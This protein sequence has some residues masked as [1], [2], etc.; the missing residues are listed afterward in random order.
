MGIGACASEAAAHERDRNV[1][2]WQQP[3]DFQHLHGVPAVQGANTGSP[4]HSEHICEVRKRKQQGEDAAR[5]AGI[6][7]VQSFGVGIRHMESEWNGTAAVRHSTLK[8]F[9]LT[10]ITD[11]MCRTTRSDWLAWETEREPLER[12]YFVPS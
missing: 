10:R 8:L 9:N 11:L 3:A 6:H 2:D 12:A 1:H 4:Q 7:R 5:Q